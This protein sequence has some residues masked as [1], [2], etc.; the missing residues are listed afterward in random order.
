MSD[1]LRLAVG[2]IFAG[3]FRVVRALAEGD[4]GAVYVVEQ[5]STG[6]ER[7][8]KLLSPRLVGDERVRARFAADARVG[9]RIESD[10]VVQVAGAGFDPE[11]GAPWIA[12]E[13]LKGIDLASHVAANG[14]RPAA[15]VREIFAQLGH[16]LG[17]AH[18][19]GIVHCDLEPKNVFLAAPRRPGVPF[20]TKVLDLG[21][22]KLVADAQAKEATVRTT[23]WLAPEQTEAG[24]AVSPAT[25]VWALGLLAFF[26]LT[27]RVFWRGAHADAAVVTLLREIVFEPMPRASVRA[28]ELGVGHLVPQGFDAWF[29]RCMAREPS[30]RFRSAREA[31]ATLDDILAGR[32]PASADENPFA[33]RAS[34][35]SPYAPTQA[36]MP[37]AATQYASPPS[38]PPPPFAPPPPYVAPP[39][40]AGVVWLVVPVV[41]GFFFLVLAGAAAFGIFMARKRAHPVAHRPDAGHIASPRVVPTATWSDSASPIPVS[42]DDPTWGN[43]DALVTVVVFSDFQCPFC[44]RLEPTLEEVKRRYGPGVVRVVWKN[45]PLAF[46]VRAMPAAEAGR[47]VFEL[48]GAAAFWDFHDAAFASPGDAAA[49]SDEK[50]EEYALAAGL[51]DVSAFRAGLASHRW[52]ARVERDAALAKTVGA[53]GTPTCFVNGVLVSGA[54]PIEKFATVI[55][56]EKAKAEAKVLSGTPRDRVY[57]VMST[58]NKGA[59]PPAKPEEEPDDKTVW[60]VPVGGSP[61]IGPATALVTI[62]EFS[63]FQCPY[64]SRVTPTLKGLEAK[65]GQQLR[66]VWKNQP[67]P[68][69]PR[70]EPAAELAL[71]ARAQKGNLG[72]WA[73]HDKLFD[74]QKALADEDLYK[75]AAELGLNVALVRAAITQ[76]RYKAEIDADA[77]LA[78][79]FKASGT[80]HFFINGRRLVGAQPKEKFEQIVDE[81]I[82]KANALIAKGTPAAQIYDT[83]TRD[84]RGP[85]E[86][87]RKVVALPPSAPWRGGAGAK[88][89]VQEFGD[90]QCPFTARAEDTLRQISA[91]YGDRVK[92]VWR[93]LA[94]PMHPDAALAAQA[95]REA[96]RQKGT[97]GFWLL[98]DKMLV[99]QKEL[100]RA[101]LDRY[102]RDLGLDMNLWENALAGSAHKAT[103]D[104]DAKAAA[105]A[106]ISGTPSFL[107]N[108]YYLNGAQPFSA[109]KK[110]ID[111]A[112]AEAR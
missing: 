111:R 6:G 52:K 73:A 45:Q 48:Q 54:Q 27:G 35:P 88:V 39:R 112:L 28:S 79:D 18:D 66:I 65:Y 80:P 26:A 93:D 76:K 96:Y 107:V 60:R 62:V 30:E 17:A 10:H 23:S 49:L 99:S 3:D 37:Y 34:A 61:V 16:A 105:D 8:L 22:G 103:I 100:D 85:T 5:L 19:A 68:F 55:D 63:D 53:S 2:S 104:A 92:I 71:E 110:V 9:A 77:S 82:A 89:V 7:A 32:A 97:K 58:E 38:A 40:G 11:S 94:L 36:A 64:C 101:S 41:I 43:R 78:D 69:H 15:E 33:P 4:A 106:G 29:A 74:N 42:S 14:P 83:L 91:T 21:I 102:A 108:G 81:E 50:L 67:L 57:V 31:L 86:P 98:H 47:G 13:L 75:Y 44:R 70:A 87:E 24:R 84:G 12:M 109:F 72:F 20:T 25:D 95:A 59:T 1:A 46:H 51:H 56:A 90:F